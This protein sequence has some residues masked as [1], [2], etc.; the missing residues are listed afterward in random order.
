MDTTF[1]RHGN[2][3][4]EIS[5]HPETGMTRCR[6]FDVRHNPPKLQCPFSPYVLGY[7]RGLERIANRTDLDCERAEAPYASPYRGI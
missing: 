3:D 2:Y 1:E 7:E 6:V 5:H 4:L